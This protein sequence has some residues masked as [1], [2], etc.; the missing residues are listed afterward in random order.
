MTINRRGFLLSGLAAPAIAGFGLPAFAQAARQT[1]VSAAAADVTRAYR[2]TVGEARVTALL[3]GFVDLQP[4]MIAPYDAAQLDAGLAA[5]QQRRHGGG[6]RIPVNA[7]VIEEAGRTV[8]VDAGTAGLMGPTLGALPAALASVGITPEQVDLVAATHLHPD[9]VGGLLAAD[10]SATFPNAEVA[11][12]E[13]EYGFWHDD[14]ILAA[15]PEGNRP[16]FQMARASLAPYA[17][18]LIR[19]QSE[20]EILPGLRSLPLP[21]HTPGHAGFLLQSGEEQLLFWGDTVHITALQFAHPEVSIV[22]DADPAQVLQTRLAMFD[23]A[24]A[25]DLLV[26]GSHLDFPG[27]GKVRGAAAGYAYQPTPWQYAL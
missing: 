25:D 1:A 20:A 7:F 24:V 8:L 4:G 17:D 11:V 26:T 2:F 16:F 6:V 15:V 9:H 18:R 5:A 14:A 13:V 10:G 22:F 19:F 23:R 12:G 27:L 21:G 3:D